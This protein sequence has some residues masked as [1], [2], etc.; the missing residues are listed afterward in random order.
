MNLKHLIEPVVS[1][2]I[3][4]GAAILE[5]YA[6]DFDV[7]AKGDDSPL[8]QADLASHR[9]IA[10]G[11]AALT[12]DVPVISEEDGLP[13]YAV[14][15]RWSRYWLIDPL[16]GTKEFISGRN[17]NVWL[18]WRMRRPNGVGGARA[19]ETPVR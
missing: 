15:S 17:E 12:P 9:C 3:D 4:A 1:L 19:G 8:T 7:Q 2:A 6:T 18:A 14:R 11:L 10:A 13:E 5:V 16:D